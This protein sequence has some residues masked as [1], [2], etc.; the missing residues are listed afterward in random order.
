MTTTSLLLRLSASVLI[1]A[2][3]VDERN[4]GGGVEAVFSA[5]FKQFLLD[6]YGADTTA[7]LERTDVDANDGLVGS[8][9][10][11]DHVAGE[12][13]EK[14]AVVF[15]HGMKSRANLTLFM[16]DYYIA[17]GNYSEAEL[18]ATTYGPATNAMIKCDYVKTVRTFIQAVAAF[19]GG[20][21]VDVVGISLGNPVARKALLGGFCVDEPGEH[22]GGPIGKS[23]VET[24]V[25]VVGINYG[26]PWCDCNDTSGASCVTFGGVSYND[27][28]TLL[29]G[30]RCG[31]AYL[32]DIN[33]ATHSPVAPAMRHYEAEN[34]FSIL[35]TTDEGIGYVVCGDKINA[36]VPNSDSVYTTSGLNHSKGFRNT[37]PQ[38]F[39]SVKKHWA[40]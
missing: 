5:S 4:G 30:I 7:H 17:N 33:G 31:S 12:R 6:R 11:G 23:H 25:S 35:T 21:R 36:V 28:C 8:Y 14:N 10:G 16:R 39:N 32:N 34:I 26:V 38:Q 2:A 27:S 18:Y 29:N 9:G 37:L 13:T 20:K 22:L 1:L 19:T 24:Y 40:F 3:A 15:V